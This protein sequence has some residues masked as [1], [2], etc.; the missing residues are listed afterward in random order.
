MSKKWNR[1]NSIMLSKI[2]VWLFAGGAACCTVF[3]PSVLDGIVA[4][5]G[6]ELQSGRLLVMAS[7]YSLLIPTVIALF[8]LY[9]LLKNI[10]RGEVFYQQ[11]ILCLRIL[12]WACYLAAVICLASAVYYIPFGFLAAVTGFMGLILRVVKNVF[13]EAL[14]LKQEND[15][16]I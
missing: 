7:F 2:C 3:L 11:N 14:A 13:A 15:Y 5:R 1:D 9:R 6:L 12:S 16:T 10:S 4:R 8:S